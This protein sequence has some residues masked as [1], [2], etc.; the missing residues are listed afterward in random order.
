MRQRPNGVSVS[1]IG[2]TSTGLAGAGSRGSPAPIAE[3]FASLPPSAGAHRD[4]S[5]GSWYGD[6]PAL[7]VLDRGLPGRF[8][9]LRIF[10]GSSAFREQVF[11]TRLPVYQLDPK[12]WVILVGRTD[13]G[14]LSDLAI[15]TGL[16]A[17]GKTELHVL[18]GASGFQQFRVHRVTSWPRGLPSGVHLMIG[19]WKRAPT[20]DRLD[21]RPKVPVLELAAI[22]INA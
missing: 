5:I 2:L 1:V 8:P 3:G 12:S 21:L 4:V 15:V 10:S 14:P 11:A 7:F 16:G 9:L 13:G 18:S 19:S 17:S 6:R 22:Q 20:L